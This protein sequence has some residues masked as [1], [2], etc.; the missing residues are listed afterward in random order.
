MS[1]PSVILPLDS[2]K[3]LS[4]VIDHRANASWYEAAAWHYRADRHGLAFILCEESNQPAC[5]K[6]CCDIHVGLVGDAFS[7]Q[8]P[9]ANDERVPAQDRLHDDALRGS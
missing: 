4:Q 9:L 2:R 5:A 8:S 6:V 3:A 1:S 7:P